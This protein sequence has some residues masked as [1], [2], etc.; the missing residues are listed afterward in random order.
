MQTGSSLKLGTAAITFVCLIGAPIGL[1]QTPVQTPAG[2]LQTSEQVFKNV[3]L[4]KGIPVDKFLEAMGMFAN[5]MGNDC[6]FCHSPAAALDRTAF[7]VETPRTLRSRGMITMMNAINKNYFAGRPRVTC[8]TCHG[9]NQSPPSDPNLALQYNPPLEDPNVRDFTADPTVAADQV[10]DRYLEAVGGVDRLAGLSSFAAKGT[11]SVFDTAFQSVPVE[12]FA[13]APGRY[14]TIVHM[15]EGNSV[16]TYDG[17]N[18][19]MAG[20]DTPLPLLTLTAG[21]LDRARLEAVL[22]FPAGLRQT[23]RQWR[24]GRAVVGDQ[25][26][27]VVQAIEAGQRIA[28]C[29]F[30]PSG[31]LVRMVRWTET[32]VGSVPTQVEYAD[33]RDEIPFRRTVTQTYM[34]MSIELSDVQPNVAIDESRFARP[35]PFRR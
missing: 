3:Q 10:L 31:L 6:T 29:Y 24:V 19:W 23:F 17:S 8:F 20:P 4:L 9:G 11:Y 34:Q 1:G 25:E 33:Y 13:M 18:G 14:T 21:N 16:R 12:I 7:A 35:E 32:P 22:S 15:S 27:F 5:A 28:N 30:E 26:G 2:A